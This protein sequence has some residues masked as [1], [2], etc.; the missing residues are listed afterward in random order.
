MKEPKELEKQV[1][2]DGY[3]AD[4]VVTTK[5]KQLDPD[6]IEA[7]IKEKSYFEKDKKS[8]KKKGGDDEEKSNQP[9]AVPPVGFFQLFRFANGFDIFLM[10]IGIV[11]SICTGLCQPLNVLLMGDLTGAMVDQALNGSQW[12]ATNPPPPE[13]IE[14]IQQTFLDA[15]VAFAVNNTILGAVM[16][17]LSF[18]AVACFD[19]AAKRQVNRIRD[20]Y[21]RSA[22]RQD[23][24]W[25]D[26][27]MTGDL[28]SKMAENITKLE[29]GIGEKVG[30]FIHFI[31]AFLGCMVLA[32]ING[33]ELTLICLISL[34]VTM[35]SVGIVAV[36]TTRLARREVEA[37]GKAGSIA[38]EV[39]SSI[40]T[41][42]AFNGQKKE[43]HRYDGN[44]IFA[45]DNN[46]KRYFFS[47]LGFGLLWFFIYASYSLSFWY[48]VGLVLEERN[49][50]PEEVTYTVAVMVTVFFGVM[51]GSMN[52]GMTSPYVE[53]FGIACGAAG[54][55]YSVIDRVPPIDS[56]SDAGE[57]LDQVKGSI[58]FKRVRFQYPSRPDVEVLKDLELSIQPGKTVALVGSS[59][60]GKSTCVQ[61]IQ[62]FYD[63]V[64]GH[65]ELDGH[66]IRTLNLNWLRN[67]IGI[68]G[69]EPVLFGAT[70]K[71][72]IR[73]GNE[74]A[75]DE[76]IIQA[77]KDANAHDFI[78]KLPQQYDTLVG[79]RGAQ[80]SG[81]QKQRVAI[82]RALIRKPAILLLDE[83]TSALDTNSEAKVQQALDRASQGRTTIIVAHRLSTIRNA[84]KIVVLNGGYVVEEGTHAELMKVHGHY[85]ELV[86]AQLSSDM[87]VH[88]R[89]KE[90]EAEG[91]G[92]RRR[93]VSESSSTHSAEVEAYIP[94]KE[95]KLK[96][97]VAP[98]VPLLKIMQ[99]NKPEWLYITLGCI[100][101]AL[102]GFSMPLFSVIFGDILGTLSNP[103]DQEVR[104]EANMFCLYFLILG[105]II[106]ISSFVQ[107]YTFGVAGERLTLRLRSQSFAAILKQ[108]VAYFDSDANSVGALCSRL[109]GD[110]ANVQGATGT[111]I[112][113]VLQSISTLVLGLSIGLF[114]E[115]RLGLVALAFA[116]FMM[117]SMFLMRRM[118]AGENQKNQ[119][120]NTGIEEASRIAVESVSN[121]RT[122]SGLCRERSIHEE[123][124]RELEAPFRKS[125]R[126][127]ATRGVVFGIARSL[128]FFAYASCMCYGGHLIVSD[129]VEYASVFKT[130]Q[131][132]IMSTMSVAQAMAFAPNF[133]K[134]L[135]SAAKIF[136]LLERDPAIKDK[137]GAIEGPLDTKGNVNYSDLHFVYPTRPNAPVL[138][139]LNL[140]IKPGQTIALVGPSGC[141][142][143]TCIQL[144][145]R[146]YDPISGA[147]ELDGRDI[148]DMQMTALRSNLGIVS[149]EPVLFD[150]TIADNIGY[151]DTSREVDI[152]EIIEAAKNA[153]IHN[154][155]TS[156]P[157]GYDTRLGEKGTQLSGGQKQRIAIA[158]ALVRNPRVLLLD[159][160]TSALD[161]ESEKV[162]QE[163][164]DK[165]RQGR[166]C[167]TIAHRL[168]TIQDADVICVVDKGQIAEA[169]KHS[170]L[171]AKGG[172]YYKLH[173]L[174]GGAK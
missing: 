132:I 118:M 1:L 123:Y 143:S 88:A 141:G 153:N 58:K 71:Q 115:W 59:G 43:S 168:T 57:K 126:Y 5:L 55:V 145:E 8:K 139:G 51:M 94:V 152:T 158:R 169:G 53:T 107:I 67:H 45:R 142:K 36:V 151:G 147:V 10:M 164:L 26:T 109:S 150:R 89:A 155:I 12:N 80:L 48:G 96:E 149:Q 173:S 32:F 35:I 70:I 161:T 160:A 68:V 65:I 125:L 159:E 13:V 25:Y 165:A 167:I 18:T 93:L 44:L 124:M 77:A 122:V 114:Y 146:F 105:I 135:M 106:G 138:K 63:P 137:Q 21:L 4:V 75:S 9:S 33:W 29:D 111:R 117:I 2:D 76:D 134:G 110:A 100:T 17:V 41:V 15:V 23:I 42:I 108:E 79:E 60:C 49:L 131:A 82:A 52:I 103:V 91:V 166:T 98:K 30:M 72:N 19:N 46:I 97:E 31:S 24:G 3:Q 34:P 56:L 92:L 140:S 156:L 20:L 102:V 99:T 116:P 14:T 174:Q 37:Y 84:D 83:A 144:L 27:N 39:L 73:Y 22:L 104:D 148:S 87:E 130:A 128:M 81:G 7:P 95:E 157:Q 127:S 112:G 119:K 86:T 66:D 113:T 64:D 129:G 40:R 11:S 74:K 16:L 172:I 62:R 90:E 136:Q 121:I 170:E 154:F 78:M 101:A 50:P 85:H 61:L 171:L 162:V 120:G 28:A 54:S 47:G 163:A 6:W 133:S 69:Q 38:E